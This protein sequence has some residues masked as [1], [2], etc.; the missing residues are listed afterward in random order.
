L[1]GSRQGVPHHSIPT[2]PIILRAAGAGA[3][4]GFQEL[5][6]ALE[7]LLLLLL[8]QELLLLLLQ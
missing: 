4:F 7:L 6:Q 8:D 2:T 1:S 5:L 3:L